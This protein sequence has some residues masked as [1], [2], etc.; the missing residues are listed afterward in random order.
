MSSRKST[1]PR[2]RTYAT[3]KDA[4]VKNSAIGADVFRFAQERV[5]VYV[6]NRGFSEQVRTHLRRL[7]VAIHVVWHCRAALPTDD[8]GKARG[9]PLAGLLRKEV[10][11]VLLGDWAL[12]DEADSPTREVGGASW[13]AL[14]GNS[15]HMGQDDQR[16]DAPQGHRTSTN[17][18]ET[19]GRVRHR[20]HKRKARA[21]VPVAH[22]SPSSVGR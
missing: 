18:R 13:V 5:F 19:P 12:A 11:L 9:V 21:P 15:L 4:F 17:P 10:R 22:G 7:P 2:R 14:S 6:E 8:V 16:A 3:H 20:L 1:Y